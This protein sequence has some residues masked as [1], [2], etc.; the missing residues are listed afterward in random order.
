MNP[1]AI[2]FDHHAI[3]TQAAVRENSGGAVLVGDGIRSIIPNVVHEHLW[4]SRA[5]QAPGA[6]VEWCRYLS[7]TSSIS[8]MSVSQASVFW[9]GMYQRLYTYLGYSEPDATNGY[10]LVLVSDQDAQG[11]SRYN[12]RQ[13]L[14]QSGF[15]TIEVIPA[16][17]A[18]LARFLHS[19]DSHVP[20][21]SGN[22]AVCFIG[23]REILLSAF[24]LETTSDSVRV[25]RIGDQIKIPKAGFLFLLADLKQWF[26]ENGH[27]EPKDLAH[28]WIEN[29]LEY[30]A[31]FPFQG[32]S[33]PSIW[34]GVGGRSLKL[35]GKLPFWRSAQFKAVL[36]SA[37]VLESLPQLIQAAMKSIGAATPTHVVFGG[38]GSVFPVIDQQLA[39]RLGGRVW[40]SQNPLEDVAIG[41]T[42]WPLLRVKN[43]LMADRL[44][45]LRYHEALDEGKNGF[46]ASNTQEPPTPARNGDFIPPWER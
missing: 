22:V 9:R 43:P 11:S 20:E 12:A 8:G 15:T 7:N 28:A 34:R 5:L 19:A 4:G 2:G 14:Q 31:S 29:V 10:E 33:Q 42:W 25:L 41:A 26:I 32:A 37:Q 21:I 3:F 27:F 38:P 24:D 23:E 35:R 16:T 18:L 6:A 1:H 40:R 13:I 30:A 17:Y 45:T 46:P 39:D 44:I 36:P